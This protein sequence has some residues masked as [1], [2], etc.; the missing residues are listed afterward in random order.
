MSKSEI[1][2]ESWMKLN[3]VKLYKAPYFFTG[4]QWPLLIYSIK[5]DNDSKC[6]IF[7]DKNVNTVT[8]AFRYCSYR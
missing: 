7:M 5:P 1:L 6:I 8:N 2:T 3:W 4:T